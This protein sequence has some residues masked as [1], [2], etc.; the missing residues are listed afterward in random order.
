ML[1]GCKFSMRKKRCFSEG[2]ITFK[3]T[4]FEKNLA[5]EKFF[6]NRPC[7]FLKKENRLA[8]Q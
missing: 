6:F 5:G 4:G 2:K 8:M 7:F 1:N 3:R